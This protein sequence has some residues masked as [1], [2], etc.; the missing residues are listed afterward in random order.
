MSN[1]KTK[2][3]RFGIMWELVIIDD[4][5]HVLVKDVLKYF[6]MARGSQGSIK[7]TVQDQENDIKYLSGEQVRDFKHIK[8]KCNVISRKGLGDFIDTRT[9]EQAKK[10]V[11][12]ERWI[13]DMSRNLK[14]TPEIW[15]VD[16]KAPMIFVTDEKYLPIYD[17]APEKEPDL[18][19]VMKDQEINDLKKLAHLQSDRIDA[20]E[21]RVK[22]L[23]KEVRQ[24]ALKSVIHTEGEKKM[25][26]ADQFMNIIQGLVK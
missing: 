13:D 22:E 25:I 8:A 10:G 11:E 24:T 7:D 18:F 16:V 3:S 26:D 2:I 4:R 6:G 20:L 17:P 15:D 5:M 23:E 19:D 12:L 1:I 21:K 9:G 14:C